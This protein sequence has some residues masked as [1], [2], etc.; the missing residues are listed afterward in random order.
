MTAARNREILPSRNLLCLSLTQSSSSLQPLDISHIC[1][2]MKDCFILWNY[3]YFDHSIS[4]CMPNWAWTARQSYKS[5]MNHHQYKYPKD[6]SQPFCWPDWSASEWQK[7]RQVSLGS[8][9]T[10]PK[11]LVIS[12]YVLISIVLCLVYN[13]RTV[14]MLSTITTR[15][16]IYSQFSLRTT[17]A[18]P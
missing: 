18:L 14:E 17:K 5:I 7:E 1:Y 4:L 6:W 16:L 11:V 10:F 9:C 2:T 3:I 12:G 8:L 13:L 15:N